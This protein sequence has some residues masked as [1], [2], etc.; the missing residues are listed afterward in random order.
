MPA[1]RNCE[2]GRICNPE[3]PPVSALRTPLR[4]LTRTMLMNQLEGMWI[5]S[6]RQWPC[7]LERGRK[8]GMA[9]S[10]FV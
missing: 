5:H 9:L 7:S 8:R 10:A 3:I 2:R 6:W 4:S 1:V